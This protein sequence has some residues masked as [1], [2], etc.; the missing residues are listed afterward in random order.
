MRKTNGII[1]STVLLASAFVLP[2]SAKADSVPVFS[3]GVNGVGALLAVN[4]S[5][6]HYII[7]SSPCGATAAFTETPFTTYAHNTLTS[8]WVTSS[9]QLDVGNF[10]YETTFSLAGLDASTAELTGS[11]ATDNEGSI[12][13][14]G[15][16]TGMTLP[17]AAF[18]SLTSF[19]ISSGFVSGLNTLVFDVHNDGSLS[20][21]QVNLTGTASPSGTSS[22]PES[23]S[24]ILFAMGLLGLAWAVRRRS[25]ARASNL[26][27]RL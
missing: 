24:L 21:L 16:T 25:K 4:V 20:G 6:P 26:A 5:D 17:A 15:A 18:G 13:L 8:Q 1:L 3:T 2:L 23:P 7:T 10:L 19:T 12:S 14:N 9:C 27:L 11:W 22:T